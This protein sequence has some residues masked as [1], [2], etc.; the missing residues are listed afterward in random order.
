METLWGITKKLMDAGFI[1][2]YIPAKHT[3]DIRVIVTGLVGSSTNRL[4]KI[5]PY[6]PRG[7]YAYLN[8]NYDVVIVYD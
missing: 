7:C 6:V 5:F 2:Q 3:E 8:S 4:D 1:V